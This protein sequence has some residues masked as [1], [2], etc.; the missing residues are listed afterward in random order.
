LPGA[1]V[2]PHNDPLITVKPSPAASI[3]DEAI[4]GG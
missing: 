1:E 4:A 3:K 2:T